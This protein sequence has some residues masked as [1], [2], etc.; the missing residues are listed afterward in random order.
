MWSTAERATT[1]SLSPPSTPRLRLRP[2]RVAGSGRGPLDGGW[3][4][5]SADPVAE[6]PG[7]ILALQAHAGDH[8]P[9]THILL[10]VADWDSR[11]RRLRVDG[12]AGTRVVRLGWFDTLPTGLLTVIRADGR[13]LDLLTVPS[14]TG[15]SAAAAAMET[16]ARAGNRIHTPGLL[17]ALT[18]PT[19]P[20]DPAVPQAATR[21]AAESAWEAEGGRLLEPPAARP[22]G[23][24]LTPTSDR[25]S[26]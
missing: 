13:R 4:P 22:A 1:I 2:S 20:T 11:P 10:A 12:P 3:W 15:H 17:A 19:G 6:L 18:A 26:P 5:R 21:A 23:P 7:L 24:A 25:R 14:G 8:S 9:I 16:A